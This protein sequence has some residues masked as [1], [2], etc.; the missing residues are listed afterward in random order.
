MNLNNS[1]KLREPIQK[2]QNNQSNSNAEQKREQEMQYALHIQQMQEFQQIKEWEEKLRMQRDSWLQEMLPIQ[3]NQQTQVMLQKAET[4]QKSEP[5]QKV[6]VRQESE[7][8]QKIEVHQQIEQSSKS[9]GKKKVEFETMVKPHQSDE[10]RQVISGE[11]MQK[12]CRKPVANEKFNESRQQIQQE[13]AECSK[14][15]RDIQRTIKETYQFKPCRQLCEMLVNIR[16]NVYKKVED[17]Q[18]DLAYVIEAFGIEEYMPKVG[19]VFEAKCHDQVYSDVLDARGRQIEQVYS[20]GFKMDGEIILK[21]QV[22][23]K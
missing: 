5:S 1:G 4:Y 19:D 17:I 14:T 11:A 16:Q 8:S 10:T 23:V 6:E 7:S 22:S 21:A 9:D 18:E 2:I 15:I 3:A 13:L 20:E 12:A